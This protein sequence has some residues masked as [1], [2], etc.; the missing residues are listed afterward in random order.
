[1]LK[2]ILLVG[3]SIVIFQDPVSGT[4]AFG[5]GIALCGLIYFKL[6]AEKLKEYL[7][8]SGRAWSEYGAKH[9]AMQKFIYFL[10]AVLIFTFIA[11]GAFPY[12]PEDVKNKVWYKTANTVG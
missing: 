1:M 4:Q 2:D 5:Y 7:G 6:G 11:G 3:A 9:P 12:L 10:I 8:G